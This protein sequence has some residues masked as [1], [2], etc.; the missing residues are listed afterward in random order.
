M[1]DSPPAIVASDDSFSILWT[2]GAARGNPGPSGV[3][4]MLKA[5]KGVWGYVA[6]RF[7]WQLL[8]LERRLIMPEREAPTRMPSE[9]RISSDIP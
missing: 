4:V 9:K 2:D 7:G 1:T 8:P 5:P 6:D 3:G